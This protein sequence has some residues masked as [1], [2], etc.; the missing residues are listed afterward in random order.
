MKTKI[1][2]FVE[3][4]L[5]ILLS[6][7]ILAE[8]SCP[9]GMRRTY[10]DDQ[11]MVSYGS[12]RAW[13]SAVC[14][15]QWPGALFFRRKVLIEPRFEVHLKA[16]LEKVDTI[17]STEE[18]KVYGFTIVISGY[19]NTIS[20]YVSRSAHTSVFDD[21]G[22]NNYVNSL[23]IE[24]D[25]QRDKNDPD[26]SSFSV[27][28]CDKQCTS[29]DS[30]AMF[31]EKLTTQQYNYNMN[32]NWDFRLIYANKQL[33]I[34]S[35]AS[36]SIF[37]QSLSLEEL[38]GTN[39][40]FVGFTGFTYSNRREI[41][42]L[43][44]FMCEDNYELP[45]M[46]GNFYINEKKYETATYQAGADINYLFSFIN[47]KNQL[48]PHTYGYD[49]WNY[50]FGI[51]SDCGSATYLMTKETNYTLILNTKAC[52][53][54]G[55]HPIH[56]LEKKKGNA[57][58]RY[59]TVV[60]GPLKK[61]TLIGHD[62]IIGPI[63]NQTFYTLVI[64][65]YGDAAT[66]DFIYKQN[67]KLVLD[68][69]VTD[70]YGN[71]VEVT[72]PNTLFNL[73]KV[74]SS[75]ETSAV[76]SNII[77]YTMKKV[78][79]H[80]QMTL[81]INKIGTYQI[82]N[83]NYME[84]MIRFSV[85]PGEADPNQSYC[86]LEGYTSPP[87]IEKGKTVLYNCYLKDSIGNDIPTDIFLQKSAYIFYCSTQRTSSNSKASFTNQVNDKG[88]YYSCE[89]PASDTG[90]YV[91]N[92]YLLPKGSQ[93]S[94][95]ISSKI[96]QFT[97]KGDGSSLSLKNVFNLY[98]KNWLDINGATITFA[99]EKTSLITAVDLVEEDGQTLLS[100]YEKYPDDFDINSLTA[101]LYSEHDYFYK[102]GEI[103][104]QF[105]EMDGKIYIGIFT[106]DGKNADTIIKKSSF[107]YK[108][109]FTLKKGNGFEEKIVTLK[110]IIN[111]SPYTTCFHDLSIQNTNLDMGW[112]LELVTGAD[113]RKISKVELKTI[114][115]Y[116]YNYDIGKE[117]VQFLLEPKSTAIEFRV[118]PLSIEGTYDVYAKATADYEGTLY[119]KIK[120]EEIRKIYIYSK[121]PEACYMEFEKPE[122]F[123]YL[124]SQHTNHFYE[125]KGDFLDGNLYFRFK[126]KDKYNNSVSK[127]DYL[128]NFADV[129]SIPFGV[130]DYTNLNITY[131]ET[132]GFYYFR[133]HL[134]FQD[135]QFTWVLFLRDASCNT[136][137]HITYDGMRRGNNPVSLDLSLYNLLQN[138]IKNGEYGYVDVI[139]KDTN[140][141]LLGLQEGKLEEI[142]AKTVVK[143]TTSDGKSVTFEFDSITSAYVIKYKF[144]FKDAGV[145]KVT[146][147]SDGTALKCGT[148][149]TLV[150]LD[151]AYSLKHS[152]MLLVLD[153]IIEMSFDVRYTIDNTVQRPFY[154]LL[155]YT[156]DGLK[157]NYDQKTNFKCKMTGQGVTLDLNVDKQRFCKIHSQ[158]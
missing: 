131:N 40:A 105:L 101:V 124:Y 65:T 151:T 148:N 27:R 70:A 74:S 52:T 39:I 16:A 97:V 110:Y 75:G 49:I 54:V 84:E 133:D 90:S 66:G 79:S 23:I 120:G 111:I 2:F 43:G 150:V 21:I 72:S 87:T 126:L 47:N 128:E 116:L 18:Q 32:N 146:A 125:Y 82:E 41:N 155:F 5:L 14:Y 157:T 83:N 99:N 51:V 142:K 45:L 98:N 135:R 118:V 61:I 156:K 86:T 114:D 8:D 78:D 80:Y 88:T 57:P 96:N 25:F 108:I 13:Y 91:V 4:I 64:L 19:R 69:A 33:Q 59:Y 37:K 145:Y 56:I 17:E 24:F 7:F 1:N 113:E 152:K 12:A 112:T 95:R 15:F 29:D 92:G 35:G 68:F 6:T 42:L 60:A 141:Q 38:L 28:Y 77:S 119:V 122:N 134:P 138:Q 129:Y 132:D 22:Y 106:K 76:T 107:D 123:E 139:Y 158:R 73:K 104:P 149:D 26:D 62:G 143:G 130:A 93:D 31:K 34:L 147:T 144:N 127:D 154:N 46:P 109:L 9:A 103:V 44:S 48:V 94:I 121:Q 58:E 115:Y 117:N 55:K 30:F 102:F 140:G 89:V 20:G 137:I 100:S 136:K 10:V 36:Q 67:L 63:L 3:L 50:T 85:I 81:E 11:S 153:T 53:K 71:D